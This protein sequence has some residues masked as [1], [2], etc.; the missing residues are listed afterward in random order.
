MPSPK[1][2]QNIVQY[3]ADN[4][5]KDSGK[6]LVHLGALGWVLSS[7]AQLG[8]IAGDKN[9]DKKKKKFLLSQE[10]ADAGVNVLMYYTICDV[11]K[12][13]GDKFV[14]NGKFLTD[15]VVK[16]LGSIKGGTVSVSD[17]KQWRN[18]FTIAELEKPLTKLLS[19]PDHLNMV[20]GL[21]DSKQTRALI[22]N[23]LDAVETHKNNVGVFSAIAASVLACNIVT[24]FV[25]NII[26]SQFQKHS[27]KKESVDFRKTQIKENITMRNPLPTSFKSFSNYNS[28]GNIKI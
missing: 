22:A 15:D 26:A 8:V 13:T 3:M 7:A 28:F 5:S 23:A 11:I 6:L 21:T 10:G 16:A 14:E 27:L 4:Y 19:K 12:K 9:I 1:L 2:L 25:R 20:K 18:L 17:P 24:P